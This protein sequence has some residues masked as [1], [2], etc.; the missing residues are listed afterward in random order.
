[1]DVLDKI[2]DQFAP[3]ELD[4]PRDIDRVDE[5]GIL[6][7]S[8]EVPLSTEVAFALENLLVFYD[9][10]STQSENSTDV[11]AKSLTASRRVGD[12]H[13]RLGEW[14]NAL[15]A[16][17]RAADNADRINKLVGTP[18]TQIN[19][20]HARVLNGLGQAQRKL[21]QWKDAAESHGQAILLVDGSDDPE[22]KFELARGLSM[23]RPESSEL[24]ETQ[25]SR[26]ISTLEG[27][28]NSDEGK[29]HYSLFLARCLS[30]KF[31]PGKTCGTRARAQEILE[32][33]VDQYPSSP[34]YRYELA[35][36]YS[37]NIGCCPESE[38][39]LRKADEVTQLLDVS[40]PN[41]PNYVRL[42]SDIYDSLAKSLRVQGRNDEAEQ[43]YSKAIEKA[44]VLFAQES[45]SHWNGNRLAGL[46][47]RR[48]EVLLEIDDPIGARQSL[49]LAIEILERLASDVSN[50]STYD[51]SNDLLNDARR[52]ISCLEFLTDRA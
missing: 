40:Y 3:S 38:K 8:P 13:F 36:I 24:R 4:I 52:R 14:E 26:A 9:Q 2:Y 16:Y 34:E 51:R 17:Q 39:M 6:V 43:Y 45:D 48:S 42:K 5:S 41:I 37:K 47:M 19:I 44:S 31:V 32:R 1:V 7:Q 46:H 15:T 27:L 18:V 49:E 25:V 35:R 20:E 23:Q 33:L 21:R 30:C 22:A 50:T 29:P 28:V 10:L 12:I 11:L